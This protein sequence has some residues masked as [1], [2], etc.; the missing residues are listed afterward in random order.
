MKKLL[1]LLTVLALALVYAGA[2]DFPD[3]P[4]D[5]SREALT[6]AVENGL[7]SG[8][9]G[10]ILPGDNLTR[11]EMAAVMVRAFG[12][13]EKADLKEFTDVPETEWYYDSLACAVKMGLFKGDAGKLNPDDFILREEAFVVIARAL[14]LS[15]I[16]A[17]VLEG[18]SDAASVSDWATDAVASLVRM[19]YVNGSDGEIQPQNYI[20][21]AEFAQ[22]MHNIF[23]SYIKAPGNYTSD[24]E[25]SVIISSDGVTLKD[26]KI[27]GDLIVA[28]GV[29]V[30]ISA[31]NVEISGRVVIRGGNNNTF[32]NVENNKIVMPVSGTVINHD[33]YG[34]MIGGESFNMLSYI[35][36]AYPGGF[37]I[38]GDDIY[39]PEKPMLT[40]GDYEIPFNVFR[41]YYLA[42]RSVFDGG[43]PAAWPAVKAQDAATYNTA[44]ENLKEYTKMSIVN[45]YVAVR[46]AIK[47][48]KVTLTDEE[49]AEVTEQIENLRTQYAQYGMTLEDVLASQH[50]D[51]DFLVSYSEINKLILKLHEKLSYDEDGNL[52]ISDERIDNYISENKYVRVQ[53]ILVET[54]E[55]ANEVCQKLAEGADFM[56]LVEEYNIDPGMKEVGE[57]GYTFGT[58]EMVPEFE[59]ASLELEIGGVS[60]PVKSD[61]GYHIIKRLEIEDEYRQTIAYQLSVE[62]FSAILGEYS[63][64]FADK[65]VYGEDI[66]VVFPENIY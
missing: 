21:R 41:Y 32:A 48:N 57:A 19:G 34:T 29:V 15:G 47:D 45:D 54:E 43:N 11:A 49:K 64:K 66:N 25:G 61:Y 40:V 62:D 53:H 13:D 33:I 5:W 30:G 28:D 8:S 22:I 14:S 6:A 55:T 42:S 24:V 9:N 17:S 38:N 16:N 44:A 23:K 51:Y 37:I 12:A 56:A 46:E 50:M 18:F 36:A 26:C 10:Y 58:G 52:K 63:K 31:E 20:T 2:V 27:G 4:D 60:A 7:I 59:N 39:V 35:I 3:M 65:A 1:V